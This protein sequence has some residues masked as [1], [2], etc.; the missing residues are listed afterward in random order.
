M[1]HGIDARVEGA[2]QAKGLWLKALDFVT[3]A[4]RFA[5]FLL[6]FGIIFTYYGMPL[7]ILRELWV[8][9]TNLR[10]C[11]QLYRK[12]QRLIRGLNERFPDATEQE[13]AA[14]GGGKQTK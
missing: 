12:Y 4:L 10:K 13:M 14:E 8:S 9:Y 6:F 2:W 7:H 11:W 5:L 3:E 1:L